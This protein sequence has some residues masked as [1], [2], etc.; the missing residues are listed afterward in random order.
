MASKGHHDGGGFGGGHHGGGFDGMADTASLNA[1]HGLETGM[2]RTDPFMTPLL[3][4]DRKTGGHR[5]PP[6]LMQPC[7]EMPAFLNGK[8]IT[9]ICP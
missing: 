6:Q 5:P 4:D 2:L 7:R 9:R 3:Y 8:K 1:G